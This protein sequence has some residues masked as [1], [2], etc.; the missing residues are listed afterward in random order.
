MLHMQ[1]GGRIYRVHGPFVSDDEVEK[2]VA[3]IKAQGQPDYLDS[4][5]D[6]VEAEP[7]EDED[8]A[9]DGAVFD[10]TAMGGDDDG[11]L[12]DRL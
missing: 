5:T 3:H 6:D 10:K 4:V 7:A 12:Y 8:D 2:V 11:S 1:G 9:A